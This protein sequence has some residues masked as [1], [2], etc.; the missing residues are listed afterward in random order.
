MRDGIR[1]VFAG[2]RQTL[3]RIRQEDLPIRC[4]PGGKN[5]A[6]EDAKTPTE[7]ACLYEITLHTRREYVLDAELD[8][9]GG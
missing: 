8:V 1:K 2:R 3:P 4:T 6:H 7:H 9:V 5:A